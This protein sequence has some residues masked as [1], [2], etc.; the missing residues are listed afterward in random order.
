MP[1]SDE[2][3]RMSLIGRARLLLRPP[4]PV[5]SADFPRL[6]ES[7]LVASVVSVLAVRAWLMATGFPRIGDGQYHIAHLLFGGLF[8]LVG[9]LL[10]LAY[11]DRRLGHFAV[12]LTGIGF[13]LFVDE[14]GKFV[15]SNND[16]FFQP[17]VALIYVTFIGIVLVVRV[18]AGAHALTSRE[19]LANALD[20][21]ARGLGHPFEAEDAARV[22][23]LLE[24]AGAG[25]LAV[26]LRA[27]VARSTVPDHDDPLEV[28][29]R[30]GRRTYE[31]I[32]ADRWFERGVTLVVAIYAV[33]ATGSAVVTVVHASP[34]PGG[35]EDIPAAA[36]AASSVLGALLVFRGAIALPIGRQAA[37]EWFARGLLVWILVT[38]VFVFYVSQ[39]EGVVGLTFDLVA[40][41]TVRYAAGRER[42]AT[43]IAA[44]R[45]GATAEDAEITTANA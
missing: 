5:R 18:L 20:R 28:I 41:M 4:Q 45:S 9:L 8:M 39:L 1:A 29:V 2:P 25:Q 21:V 42:A 35:G 12:V 14:I 34:T 10:L 44:M 26:E 13:G 37:Y 7:F 17:A 16:Y 27:L 40:Y 11:L 22:S 19:A 38:Q 15:T 30:W 33:A 31:R 23:E 36:Q 3:S 43:R 32:V 6:A 24:L